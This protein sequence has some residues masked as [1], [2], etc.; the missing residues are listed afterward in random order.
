MTLDETNVADYADTLVLQV[1]GGGRELD[2]SE[3]SVTVLEELLCVSDPLLTGGNFPDAQRNIVAFYNGCYLGEV[4]ARNLGGA[5]RF[6]E[7]WF[8]ASLVVPF[9]EG[10]LQVFPFQKVYRRLTEGADG[11]DLA[12]YYEGVRA[13]LAEPSAA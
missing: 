5:W 8:D 6:E 12:R 13:K 4:I 1:K 2:Y 7:N 10:G 3:A 9:G 11:H